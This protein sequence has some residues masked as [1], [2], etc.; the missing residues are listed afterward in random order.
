MRV[1]FVGLHQ[2]FREV[3]V[4]LIN[5]TPGFRVFAEA[6]TSREAVE[7]CLRDSLDLA[8]IAIELENGDGIEV[9]REILLVRPE[10]RIIL[11]QSDR[12]EDVT[13]RGLRSGAFGLVFTKGP[14]SRLVEALRAVAQGRS[15]VGPVAWDGVLSRL[16][17]RTH[18]NNPTGLESLSSLHRQVLALILEGRT[19]SEIAATLGVAVSTIWNQRKTLMRRMDVK[20]TPE[21][22]LVAL[23]KGFKG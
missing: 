22:V 10:T 23:A 18:E 20:T 19:T 11:M 12:D 4:R 13:L 2:M 8:V 14:A 9:T 15:Y 16:S 3:L 21:L 17:G 6:E 1:L 7:T 5:E